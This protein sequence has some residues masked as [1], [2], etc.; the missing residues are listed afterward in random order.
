MLHSSFW[1]FPDIGVLGDES[2]D[3]SI[4][5]LISI[6]RKTIVRM[7]EIKR[8]VSLRR[9]YGSLQ[10][11]EIREFAPIVHGDGLEQLGKGY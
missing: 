3:D 9:K 4:I 5:V 2:A 11:F 6:T 7:C 1:V 10:A 8:H